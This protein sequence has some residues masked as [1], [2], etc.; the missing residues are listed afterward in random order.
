M[1]RLIFTLAAASAAA[2]AG[3]IHVKT[4]SEIKPIHIT[5]DVNLKV[6]RELDKAF[7]EESKETPQGDYK[8]IKDLIERKVV[9][10]DSRAMLVERGGATDD[11]RLFIT[12]A[13]ARRMK[14][15]G[16]IA[17]KNGTSLELVQR[18]HAAKMRERMAVG[19]GAWY[20]ENSGEWHQ[21]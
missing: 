11:D 6:D 7:A 14:R 17:K 10:V 18:R 20:Q 4:E 21:K 12:D 5:M 19:S 15:F 16:E 9:G 1:N 13:N 2:F 3:C 8:R